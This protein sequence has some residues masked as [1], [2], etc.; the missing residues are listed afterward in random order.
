[1]SD[2]NFD[3]KLGKHGLEKILGPLES[4]IMECIWDK[5]RVSVRDI[6]EILIFQYGKSMAYTTVMTIMARLA[7]KNVLFRV[8][9]DGAYYYEAAL[10]KEDFLNNAVGEV[11][12]NLMDDFTEPAIAHFIDKISNVDPLKLQQ[13]EDFIAKQKKNNK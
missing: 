7:K 11:V 3:F 1:M 6:H 9:E 10:A 5:G 8:K 13:L 2:R 4:E 12:N